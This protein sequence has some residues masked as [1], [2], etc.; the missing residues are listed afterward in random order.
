MKELQE[1]IDRAPVL[2]LTDFTGLSVKE[3]TLLR[4]SLKQN[5]AGV[6]GQADLV[7]ALRDAETDGNL[8]GSVGLSFVDLADGLFTVELDF[9]AESFDGHAS[10]G[11]ANGMAQGKVYV[12]G[13][14]GSRGMTMTKRNPR[15]E[16][17]EVWVLGSVGD[18]FGEFMAGGTAIGAGLATSGSRLPSSARRPLG[19][20]PPWGMPIRI[21]TSRAARS[22]PVCPPE[23]IFFSIAMIPM[24]FF[25]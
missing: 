22:T 10:N 18:Y 4:R 11:L 14:I 9:G 13:N 12:G 3:M 17:P 5:G 23:M 15:F 6:T 19:I 2:Y 1:R 7:F 8:G 24:S 21:A 16:P 25:F 20:Q